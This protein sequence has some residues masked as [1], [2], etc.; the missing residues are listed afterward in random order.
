MVNDL[1]QNCHVFHDNGMSGIVSKILR[2]QRSRIEMQDVTLIDVSQA[3]AARIE[4]LIRRV[5]T[6]DKKINAAIPD[7]IESVPVPHLPNLEATAVQLIQQLIDTLEPIITA[8]G[9][10]YDPEDVAMGLIE[11]SY[12]IRAN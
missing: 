11:H 10:E 7:A 4:Q 12:R 1:S 6:V 9:L 8:Q 2:S 3:Q 5:Q